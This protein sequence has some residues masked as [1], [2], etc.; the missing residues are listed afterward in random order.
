MGILVSHAFMTPSKVAAILGRVRS[1]LPALPALRCCSD[2]LVNFVNSSTLVGW[3]SPL[4]AP[5]SLKS[6]VLETKHLLTNWPGRVFHIS[7]SLQVL[8]LASDASHVARGVVGKKHTYFVER[9]LA[10]LGVR[11]LDLRQGVEGRGRN[12][13]ELPR[14]QIHGRDSTPIVLCH[15]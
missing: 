2:H 4:P 7:P 12:D 14:F 8:H 9:F 10:P 15:S 5:P 13:H 11:G 1:L 3:D 6:Q